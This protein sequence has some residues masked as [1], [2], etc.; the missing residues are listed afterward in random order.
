MAW[1]KTDGGGCVLQASKGL[2]DSQYT[3]IMETELKEKE[4]ARRLS[5]YYECCYPSSSLT[6]NSREKAVKIVFI[7]NIPVEKCRL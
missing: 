7:S 5:K 3:W 6:S 2:S 4:E 1:Q